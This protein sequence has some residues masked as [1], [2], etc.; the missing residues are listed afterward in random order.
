MLNEV[1]QIKTISD[2]LNYYIDKVNEPLFSTSLPKVKN[3][4]IKI[5]EELEEEIEGINK[6]NFFQRWANINNLEAQ[7]WILLELS[8]VTAKKDRTIFT[9]EEV[10]ITAK[11]DCKTYFKEKCGMTLLDD[12]PHSLHFSIN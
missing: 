10:V 9:E 5:C 11:E 4:I 1:F 6:D 12:T 7:I 3:R 2:Y 8:E